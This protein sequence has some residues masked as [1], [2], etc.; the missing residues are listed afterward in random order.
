MDHEPGCGDAVERPVVIAEAEDR[1]SAAMVDKEK[2][3]NT[4]T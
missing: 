4:A 2:G 1:L 3:R